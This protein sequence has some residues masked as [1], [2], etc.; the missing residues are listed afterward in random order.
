MG[1]A[2]N[3]KW[4]AIRVKVETRE[5]LRAIGERVGRPMHWV[6]DELLDQLTAAYGVGNEGLGLLEAEVE[7]R[8]GE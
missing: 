3:Q 8:R 1:E 5:R 4:P 6:I 7:R 2:N